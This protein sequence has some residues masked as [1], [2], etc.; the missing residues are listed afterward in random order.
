MMFEPGF[1]PEPRVPGMGLGFD[2]NPVGDHLV[3]GHGGILPGFNSQLFVA[4][5]DGVGVIAFTTGARLAM[6]WLPTELGRLLR[7]ILGEPRDAIRTDVPQ[8]PETWSELCGRYGYTGRLLDVRARMMTG[9]GAFVSVDGDRLVL[10]LLSPIP[11]MLR[12][13]ALVPDDPD[14]P[15]VFRVDLEKLGLPTARVVF[16]RDD[17]GVTGLHLD[18]F[19]MSLRKQDPP[20]AESRARFVRA[21]GFSVAATSAFMAG[22]RVIAT[23]RRVAV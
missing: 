16:S 13:F 5:E 12:G 9:A 11:A 14:D 17:R 21:V 7:E 19:P 18:I 15:Y 10:R 4:P 8:R 1:Q 2:R 20:P 3:V 6:L 23:R 22:R